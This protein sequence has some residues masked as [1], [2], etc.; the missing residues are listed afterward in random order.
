LREFIDIPSDDRA[1]AEEL[2][3][4]GIAV[5]SVLKEH[6]Q[7]IFEMEI[8]TNR[9][10]AMNHYGIA[11]ECSAIYDRDL[12]AIAP[13]LPKEKAHAK[14]P[15]EIED[16]EGCARYTARMIQNVE[17]GPSPKNI[18]ERLALVGASSISNAVD[19]SNYALVEMGH[20]THAFD[21][22]LL[23]GGRIVVRRARKGE[24]VKTLDGVEH[25]LEPDDLVIADGKRPVALAGIMGG[26]DTM[27]T[28]IGRAHV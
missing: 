13:K 21:L 16:A 23:A 7:T 19:A 4:T 26:F 6:G 18:A 12:N 1:L 22:D 27:I 11:R 14:F 17:V 9:V 3:H 28:E 8:T 5:E 2:T 24:A 25:K 20:P 10:D 15:I